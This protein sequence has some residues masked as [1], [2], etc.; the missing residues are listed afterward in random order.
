MHDDI[1]DIGDEQL[2]DEIAA[3][4]DAVDPVPPDLGDDVRVALT[5]QALEAE[6]AELVSTPT[7]ALRADDPL[8]DPDAN[9][10]DT[11]TFSSGAVSLAISIDGAD[12]ET[13]T[14][15]GWITAGGASVELHIGG[16]VRHV[17]ADE[18]GRFVMTDVPRRRAWFV[19]R[20]GDDHP[21][22][23]TPVIEL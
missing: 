4:W 15:D 11:I 23:V 22:I 9:V 19:A 20:R 12:D 5:V 16:T 10:V 3:M 17:Q 2:L 1:I 8:D 14:I 18:F 7:L 21:P 13:V 6:I